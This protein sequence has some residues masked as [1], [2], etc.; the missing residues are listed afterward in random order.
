MAA[1]PK[2]VLLSQKDPGK[3]VELAPEEGPFESWLAVAQDLWGAGNLTPFDNVFAS[4]A[5]GALVPTKHA[6]FGVLGYHLGRRLFGFGRESDLWIDA[7]EGE[8]ALSRLEKRP[9]D[10]VK[11]APWVPGIK[12]LRPARYSHLAVL[13]PS[14][15]A[16]EQDR[17]LREAAV[18]LKPGGCLFL[19]ELTAARDGMTLPGMTTFRSEADYRGWLDATGLSFNA[20]KDMTHDVEIALLHGLSCSLNM[21]AI[22]RTLSEPWRKQRLD[23]FRREMESAVLLHTAMSHGAVKATGLLYTKN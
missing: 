14:R 22:A 23:A 10:K 8:A 11:L 15:L 12:L 6:A 13:M 1:S 18:A 16:G 19:A 7:F 3:D 4:W 20:V 21:L 17:I 9:K 2:I 5:I